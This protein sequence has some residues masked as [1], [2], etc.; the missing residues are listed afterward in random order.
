MHPGLPCAEESTCA[1]M[2]K[3]SWRI[4]SETTVQRALNMPAHCHSGTGQYR[5]PPASDR[6]AQPGHGAKRAYLLEDM[7]VYNIAVGS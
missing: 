2:D 5:L 1:L 3:E 6:S 7:L 4:G